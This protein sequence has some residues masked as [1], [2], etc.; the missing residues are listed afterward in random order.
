MKRKKRIG[1]PQ[2]LLLLIVL[3]AGSGFAETFKITNM[4]GEQVYISGG[5]RDGLRVGDLVEI[6]RG[7]RKVADLQI[8]FVADNSA[9]CR[10]IKTLNTIRVGDQAIPVK[11]PEP[12]AAPSEKPADSLAASPDN[13]ANTAASNTRKTTG[14]RRGMRTSGSIS[15][16]YYAFDD[17]TPGNRDF[18]Q[19]TFRL[20][21]RARQ[22]WDR[23]IAFRVRTR[24]R[25]DQREQSLSET[26][27][28]SEWNNRLYE[29]SLY[30]N[31]RNVPFNWRLGR[32]YSNHISTVGYLDGVQLQGNLSPQLG[33]GILAGTVPNRRTSAFDS[34][35]Q[36]YG[37][38]TTVQTGDPRESQLQLTLA[39]AMS[40]AEGEIN[41]EFLYL[42]TNYQV[43]SRFSLYHSSELD[44]NRGWRKELAGESATLSNLFISGRVALN[45][46]VALGL[47]YDDRQNFWSYS[48][49]SLA[50]SLFDDATRRGMRMNASL[51]L[52]G[53]IRVYT[54]GGF[55]KR[56]G[57]SREAWSYG[58]GISQHGLLWPG[59]GISLRGSGF[60]NRINQGNQGSFTLR[61]SFRSGHWFSYSAGNYYYKLRDGGGKRLTRWHR[62]YG[63]F[64][65]MQQFFLTG[66]IEFNSGEDL[67]GRRYWVELG[68]RF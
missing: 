46:S 66:E 16:Q 28:A 30:Y 41:R 36:Q 25:Y 47:S 60:D 10:I 4:R 21:F 54:N 22:M 11:D 38:Y 62:I 63:Y 56:S 20:N 55:R 45:N 19:P 12:S 27:P 14:R 68:Y 52:P 32:M 6:H 53:R 64:D 5:A 59:F 26:I 42:F 65:L 48:T 34:K 67:D 23:D 49:R 18:R 44:I 51:K 33:M 24:S 50:D 29:L 58:G 7:G 3:W 35:I 9:V 61:Q 15:A 13:G 1:L 57:E 17:K 31:D 37:V 40:Y 8:E 2:I 43:G 39:G